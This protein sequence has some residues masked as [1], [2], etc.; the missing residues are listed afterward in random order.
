MTD[1]LSARLNKALIYDKQLASNVAAFQSG[2]PLGGAFMM[3]ATARPG[4][5]LNQIEQ[6]ISAEIARL[7]KDGPTVEELN[8]AKTKWEFGFISGLERIG[9]FGGKSDLLN[10][11][12]TFLGDPGKFDEDLARHRNVTAEGIKA[13]VDK[14]LNTKNRVLVRFRSGKIRSAVKG[15]G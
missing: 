14:Y 4:V 1:G 10:Q 13:T 12:N 9:G 6:I 3:W 15:R 5:D 8:R 7:A 11:Y 2:Q